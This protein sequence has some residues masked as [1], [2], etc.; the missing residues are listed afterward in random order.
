MNISRV[1]KPMIV[2]LGGEASKAVGKNL[3]S[4]MNYASPF[5]VAF[6]NDPN[7]ANSISTSKLKDNA[8]TTNKIKDKNVTID[9][10]SDEVREK[11]VNDYVINFQLSEGSLVSDKTYAQLVEAVENGCNIVL[12]KGSDRLILTHFECDSGLNIKAISVSGTT[13]SAWTCVLGIANNTELGSTYVTLTAV[14]E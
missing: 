6:I 3:I 4:L 9:K 10:L 14:S 8:I 2:A 5:I 1:L 13:L 7:K 11:L 12:T